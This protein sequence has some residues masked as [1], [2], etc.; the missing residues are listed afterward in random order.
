ML[1]KVIYERM[2][3]TSGGKYP[4][5]IIYQV[6]DTD[7]HTTITTNEELRS[8]VVVGLIKLYESKNK[9]IPSNI[10]RYYVWRFRKNIKDALSR[11]ELDSA[12]IALAFPQSEYTTKYMP[13]VIKC[14]N[15]QKWINGER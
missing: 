6:Y 4:Y 1:I 9:L 3:K 5:D 14:L 10:A 8:H 15:I 13:C 11:I 7:F 12:N 2:T